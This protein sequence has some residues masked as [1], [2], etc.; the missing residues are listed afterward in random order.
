LLVLLST[1]SSEPSIPLPATDGAPA[2]WLSATQV[3][4]RF[5]LEANWLNEHRRQLSALGI[6]SRVS[7]KTTLYDVKKLG[8]FIESR[9]QSVPTNEHVA[10]SRRGHE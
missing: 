1:R 5:G 2:V 3:H 6:T 9:R 10:L 4:E 7:R 8:R